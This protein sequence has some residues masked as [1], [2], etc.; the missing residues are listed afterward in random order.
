MHFT[1]KDFIVL[2]SELYISIPFL[3]CTELYITFH[4]Y[5]TLLCMYCHNFH[6]CNVLS[7]IAYIFISEMDTHSMRLTMFYFL[8]GR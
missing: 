8:Y 2:T 6:V 5:L 1:Y 4:C 3:S 7:C